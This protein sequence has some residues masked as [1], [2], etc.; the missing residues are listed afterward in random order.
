M[1]INNTS[2]EIVLFRKWQDFRGQSDDKR[3][4]DNGAAC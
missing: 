3:F 4:K 1:F 2:V